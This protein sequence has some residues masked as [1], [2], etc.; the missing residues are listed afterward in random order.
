MRDAGA[1][2][3][4]HDIQQ[5][6]HVV[7]GSPR[8][9]SWDDPSIEVTSCKDESSSRSMRKVTPRLGAQSEATTDTYT[10]V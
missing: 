1:G 4:G 7:D 8:T 2:T 6:S 10:I 9:P 3:Y 5:S